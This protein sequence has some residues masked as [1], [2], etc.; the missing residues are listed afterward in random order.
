MI[1]AFDPV[2]EAVF[3]VA[4]DKSG[5]WQTWYHRAVPLADTRFAEHLAGLKAEEGDDRG[6]ELARRQGQGSCH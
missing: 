4:G 3:L 6:R 1:F 5:R 2:R